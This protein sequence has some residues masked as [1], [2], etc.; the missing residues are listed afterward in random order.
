[1]K[2][3]L[4]TH[5]LLWAAS[6]S[7]KLSQEARTLLND[8]HNELYFSVVSIWKIAIK[9]SLGKPEF[10]INSAAF[11]RSLLD[12]G[13]QEL[14]I[15]GVHATATET[16]LEIHKDPFDRMLIAQSQIEGIT[17]LSADK[18][19]IAYGHLVQAI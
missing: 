19:M 11:R 8:R 17:L 16:L 12:S 1:M 13:Y 15:T 10:Q 5:L 9:T 3:L 4:D 6:N 2:F 14:A 7:P 18:K